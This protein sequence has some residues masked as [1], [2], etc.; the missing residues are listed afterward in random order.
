MSK[1][2]DL[3]ERPYR[4]SCDSGN[5]RPIGRTHERSLHSSVEWGKAAR[6]FSVP[7]AFLVSALLIS[8][9]AHYPV[10]APLAAVDPHAGYR[11]QNA[12][13]PTNADDLLLML[14]FSAGG[15]RS[16]ALSYGVLEEL[17]KTEVGPPG[18]Q[19]RLLDD[20]G[21]ISSTS[22][23]SFTAAYYAV[24]GDRIFSDFEPLFL[25]KHVQTDLFLWMLTPWN[26]ARLASPK[27]NRS[28]LAAEYYDRLLFKGATFG[29]L[30]PR[31]SRP[32]LILNATDVASGARFEFTQDEFDL[33]RSDLSEFPIARA[34]AASAAFP[35]VFSPVVL[36]NHSAK[37]P[38]AGPEWMQSILADPAASS[39]LKNLALHARSYVDGDRR[40]FIHL[41]DGGIS[42][43]LGLRGPV[44]RA[45]AYEGAATP[46]PITPRRLPRRVA[47]II[48]DAQTDCDY[49]WDTKE[50]S[51]GLRAQV[52]S[53]GH[54]A[55]SRNSFETTELFRE[56]TARVSHEPEPTRF[57]TGD[58]QPLEFITYT[59]ELHFNRSADESNRRFFNS[60]PTRLQLPSRTVDRLKHLAAMELRQN[61]EFRNLVEDLRRARASTPG[62]LCQPLPR[63]PSVAKISTAQRSKQETP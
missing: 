3:S 52:G 13:P 43:P 12:A 33:I 61:Q 27:F 20:V 37:S 26:R 56:I 40:R 15:A 14:T 23:G 42:D 34:V 16:A 24:W 41:S 10:N 35:V 39:R 62:Q 49:G 11:F 21:L 50:G 22:G 18:N 31:P 5:T 55:V 6:A 36:K 53:I 54:A 7:T 48:V 30:T 59:V 51:L 44:D 47:V 60:V 1:H 8:G 19:H 58:S 57:Q 25:K 29:S 9:C 38:L 28:D 32:F 46:S 17:A 63:P 4:E 2:Q 45:I